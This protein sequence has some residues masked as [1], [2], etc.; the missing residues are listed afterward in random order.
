MDSNIS[1]ALVDPIRVEVFIDN[2]EVWVGLMVLRYDYFMRSNIIRLQT[3]KM[4]T[5]LLY[6]T[7]NV[8]L[9]TIVQRT[10]AQCSPNLTIVLKER[11]FLLELYLA[12][13]PQCSSMMVQ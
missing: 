10:E 12:R 6:V 8:L 4:S 11:I 2:L 13:P 7:V 5:S 1:L 3:P 9:L